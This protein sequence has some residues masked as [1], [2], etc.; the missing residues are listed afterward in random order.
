MPRT[1]IDPTFKP[2]TEQDIQAQTDDGSFSRGRSYA[3]QGRIHDTVLRG[4]VIEALCD[5]SDYFPYVVHARL[6]RPGEAGPNPKD[7]SCTCPRGDFCKHIVALLLT[8]VGDPA[9]FVERPSV[10]TAIAGKN[11]GELAALVQEMIRRYPD[12]ELLLDTPMAAGSGGSGNAETIDEGTIRRQVQVATMYLDGWEWGSARTAARALEAILDLGRRY[13]DAGQWANAHVVYATVAADVIGMFFEFDDSDGD[14]TGIITDCDIGLAQCLEVQADLPEP[15]R[16]LPQQ[17]E[18]LVRDIYDIWRFDALELGGI[19]LSDRGQDALAMHVTDTERQ[20]VEEWL[21][22]EEGDGVNRRSIIGFLVTLREEA[23]A[24]D[25]ELLEIYR[26]AEQWNDVAAMLVEMGRVSE[27]ISIA[28]RHINLPVPLTG[29]ADVLIQRG[30]GD[31]AKALTL[32]DDRLWEQEGKNPHV[33]TLLQDWLIRQYSAHGRPLDALAMARKRFAKQAASHTYAKV[34]DVARLPEV[35][36]GTW[37]D[38]RAEMLE[39]FRQMQAWTTLADIYLEEGDVGA[40]LE[41]HRTHVNMVGQ[42]RA[43]GSWYGT[44]SLQLAKAAE[45]DFP[46]EAIAIYRAQADQLIGARNRG[47]YREAAAVLARVKATL[48]Q[49]GKEDEWPPLIADLRTTHKTL[50][51]LQDELDKAGL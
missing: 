32:V 25:E 45:R 49:H 19:G 37:D 28:R 48:E 30:G 33:D 24:T 13:G 11:P 39:T 3:R 38:V 8:W 35:G 12:L 41:A 6:A 22:E 17:R 47:S 46:D 20:M 43:H 27:A 2:L 16:L 29:F 50:R 18:R 40:A 34:R 15:E 51:A 31:I 5:G 42:L 14:L 36:P 21:R 7:F 1:P 4:D 10:A 44:H 23:G 9:R 26:E